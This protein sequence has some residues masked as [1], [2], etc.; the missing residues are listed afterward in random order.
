VIQTITLQDVVQAGAVAYLA[1]RLSAQ[2]PSPTCSYLDDAGCPCVVGAAMTPETINKLVE[3]KQLGTRAAELS[4]AGFISIPNSDKEA[5]D[6]L[7]RSHDKWASAAG[8]KD[9]DQM[10]ADRARDKEMQFKALLKHHGAK[11]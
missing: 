6:Q 10:A 5:V 7:Q 4:K 1:G 3:R 11:I 8:V 2:G 9:L